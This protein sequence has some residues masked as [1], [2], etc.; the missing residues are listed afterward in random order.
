M[1]AFRLDPAPSMDTAAVEPI[2]NSGEALIEL[3][4]AGICDTDLQLAQGYMEFRGIP[5]HEFVGRVLECD[6]NSWIGARV[7]GDINAGCG[8]C[9]DCVERDGHH[10]EKRSVLGILA[11]PGCLAERFTLPLGN[12]VRVPDNLTDERAVFAEPLAAGLHVLREV[13]R[14]SAERVLVLGDGKLGLLTALALHASGVD[15]T[16]VGH[17][18][19]K[20]EIAR[21]A[22]ATGILEA[23]LDKSAVFDL[24]VE[25]TGSAK[26]LQRA[27]QIVRP[28]GTVVLKTTVALPEGIDLSPIVIHELQVI[29]SRCGDMAEAVAMLSRGEI[30]PLPLVDKR[31]ALKETSKAFER[32]A[33]RGILKVL[34][35][36]G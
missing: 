4:V 29:G 25:A 3:R 11:R 34:V 33:Q 30:N 6:E 36:V 5:G 12:L 22:G 32:A 26:G 23:D 24:V 7:V 14:S 27:L 19:H 8:L 1:L 2:V 35:T 15:V 20:L 31:F 9:A 18:E 21:S 13:Q 17:H 10:C 16:V 28:R